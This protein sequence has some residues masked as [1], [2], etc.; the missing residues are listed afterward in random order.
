[1]PSLVSPEIDAYVEAH[2]KGKVPADILRFLGA[3]F[4]E[5]KDFENAQKY[6]QQLTPRKED[7][8][9]DDWLFLGRS[10]AGGDK[11]GDAVKSFRAYLDLVKNPAAR[12]TGL[13]ELGRAEPFD[14]I[15]ADPPYAQGS[16][17]ALVKAVADADW[18]APGGWMSVETSRA[19]TI[20]PDGFTVEVTR[21]VGRAR[22]A[23]A[24]ADRTQHDQHSDQEGIPTRARAPL[25]RSKHDNRHR[26]DGYRADVCTQ[27]GTH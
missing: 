6:F 12:A 26:G 8:M 25:V 4:F 19:D 13:L 7:T 10:Q 16:G 18:L 24:L 1:M 23:D 2:G 20:D 5:D 22:P 15:L 9:P 21:D 17:S 14:L 3:K 27:Q 11:C